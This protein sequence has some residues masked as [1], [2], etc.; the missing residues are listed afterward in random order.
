ML[1]EQRDGVPQ[2][3]GSQSYLVG[4][5][6]SIEVNGDVLVRYVFMACH[7]TPPGKHGIHPTVV[8]YSHCVDLLFPVDSM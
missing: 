3:Q 7:T 6:C 8:V 1:L 4:I 5:E 2:Q